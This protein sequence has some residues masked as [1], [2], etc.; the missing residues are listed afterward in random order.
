[1]MDPYQDYL[2][3]NKLSNVQG[4]ALFTL[5]KTWKSTFSR[6]ILG[7]FQDDPWIIRIPDPTMGQFVW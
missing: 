5:N 1:M 6:T 4:I 7:W 2:G 3:N